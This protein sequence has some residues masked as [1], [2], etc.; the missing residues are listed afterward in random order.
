M[1]H[2][3]FMKRFGF[4][5]KMQLRVTSNRASQSAGRTSW[6]SFARFLCRAVNRWQM[7][8]SGQDSKLYIHYWGWPPFDGF[9]RTRSDQKHSRI[10]HLRTEICIICS[11]RKG[12][13]FRLA[14]QKKQHRE[15]KGIW[16]TFHEMPPAWGREFSLL[17]LV[18]RQQAVITS[19]L[20]LLISFYWK[21]I[22][23][24]HCIL[25]KIPIL[26]WKPLRILFWSSQLLGFRRRY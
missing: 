19:F 18:L 4:C 7:Q 15:K 16:W 26:Y 12:V 14:E 20:R 1:R 17:L 25:N 5:R 6:R 23:E 21:V 11:Y 8:F 13:S 3:T 22:L 2:Q 9:G 24:L 10:V